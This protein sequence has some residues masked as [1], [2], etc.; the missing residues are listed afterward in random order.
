[1]KKLTVLLIITLLLT[2]CAATPSTVSLKATPTPAAATVATASPAAVATAAPETTPAQTPAA[3]TPSPTVQPT[4][5]PAPTEAPSPSPTA[6]PAPEQPPLLSELCEKQGK[7]L[8]DMDCEQL[9]LVAA[10]GSSCKLY[11]YERG[12]DGIW[13]RVLSSSGHVGKNGVSSSKKEGDKKTPAGIYAMGFAFGHDSDPT[14]N[15]TYRT[16]TDDSYW[17]DDPDSAH[18]NQWVEGTEDK[19]WDSAEALGRIRTEYAL[20]VLIEYNYGSRT[21]PGKGSAIFL[22]VDDGTTA[23]CIAIPKADL[24]SLLK[25][26]DKDKDP[27]II[28]S[29]A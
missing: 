3:A 12:A 11:T 22:H 17:V 6:T 27:H 10:E 5:T 19:D 18:Y 9:I 8:E 13:Q 1:M 28:I 24:K 26:L 25:W 29:N 7:A 23:G 2:S 21:V 14:G 15:Y 4:A 16:I 20:A